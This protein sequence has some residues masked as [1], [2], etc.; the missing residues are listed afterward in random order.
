MSEVAH[1]NGTID[2]RDSTI[3]EL[4]AEVAAK[5]RDISMVKHSLQ[6]AYDVRAALGW[7]DK[8][9]LDIMP[10][11]IKRLRAERD[12]AL[13]DL[14]AL[15]AHEAEGWREIASAP[16]EPGKDIL[17][18]RPDAEPDEYIPQVGVDYWSAKHKT[19]MRS[20]QNKQP[21]HWR[22]LPTKPER[23]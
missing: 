17:V 16:K 10:D 8:T 6:L 18:Y 1:V 22:P 19:W 15:R 21:S 11:A 13:A 3:A 4:R 7:N 12:Q 14:A 9:S 5:S 20:N 23:T 2:E